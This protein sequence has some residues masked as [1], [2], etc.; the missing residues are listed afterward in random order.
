MFRAVNDADF[1]Q[2]CRDLAPVLRAGADEA[3]VLRRLPPS[4]SAAM[5]DADILRGLTPT[6]LGGHGI[7]LRSFCEG[8][9]E[10][11]TGCPASAWTVSFLVLHA[12]LL[13]RFP[14]ACHDDLFDAG[15]VPTAAAPLA[16]TGRLEVVADG[17][18][19]H[20]RWE[21]ATAINE[22]DWCIVHGFDEGVE[23][24]TRFA[25]LP[26]ADVTVEDTWHTSGMR[27][28]GSHTVV[29]DDVLVPAERTCSGDVLRT[30]V[31]PD[32]DRLGG[33]PLIPVLALAASA[34]AVGAAD[35]AVEAFRERLAGRVLAYSLGDRAADQPV[36]LARLA[37]VTD[38]RDVAL[39][40]WRHA[41]DR[42]EAAAAGDAV[43][44]LLR[45]RTRLAAASAVRTAR[46]VI[47]DVGEG[48]G[49][50]VYRSDHPIQRLQRDVETLK[51]HAVFDW[52]R[53]TELAGRVMMGQ[54]LG[55]T[56]MA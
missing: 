15:L 44:D 28:T 17:Y 5:H 50:S 9:R 51:G 38:Q 34:S 47:G 32:G 45:A 52:D 31:H 7:G 24:G 16:P 19:V 1:V 41:I 55:P 42:L 40:G 10:L 46:L 49:A 13:S 26:V 27:A 3:E 23:L 12:W 29:V 22:S 54:P 56:D 2:R 43:D 30:A 6:S 8:T 35:A 37:A 18:R 33:L 48:A 53:T 36:M 14:A 11:A 21:W 20:G 25:V 4:V 39:A